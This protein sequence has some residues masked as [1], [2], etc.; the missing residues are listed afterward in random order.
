MLPHAGINQDQAHRSINTGVVGHTLTFHRPFAMSDW[1]L[2]R[3]EGLVA[4]AGRSYGRCNAF[5]SAGNLVASYV[6]D[7]MIRPMS[8]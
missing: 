3:H 2:L 6:Q 4:G 7:N 1:T 8:A 5:D